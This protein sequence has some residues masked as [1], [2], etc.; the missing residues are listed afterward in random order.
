[1]L[2]VGLGGRLDAVNIFEPDVSVVVSVDLDHQAILGDNREDI[3]FEKAGIY[4]AGKPALCADPKP[5]ARLIEHAR[6]IGADLK[7]YGPDFGFQRM[8]NQWSFPHGRRPSPRLAD[9]GGRAAATRWSTP[10]R[11]WRCW[12]A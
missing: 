3:G 10:R 4:R 11:R 9:S 7:L 8:D 2:E 5:P 6:A 1:M 12:N